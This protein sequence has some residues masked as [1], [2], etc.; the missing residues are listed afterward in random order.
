MLGIAVATMVAST[1]AMNTDMVQAASTSGRRVGPIVFCDCSSV[2]SANASRSFAC[3]H[4][5]NSRPG[6]ARAARQP[7]AIT[8]DG[9]LPPGK[10]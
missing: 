6:L 10:T 1:A 8:G 9:R 2:V 3:H 7:T 4:K 5:A